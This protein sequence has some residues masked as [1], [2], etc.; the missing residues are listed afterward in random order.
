MAAEVSE[1]SD[2]DHERMDTEEDESE[3]QVTQTGRT[4]ISR[5]RKVCQ[6]FYAEV[7]VY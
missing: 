6:T 2:V 4:H 3:N 7:L 5:S 1:E